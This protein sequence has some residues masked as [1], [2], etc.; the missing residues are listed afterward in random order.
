M[1]APTYYRSLLTPDEQETYKVIVNCLIRHESSICVS[2]SVVE[3][4]S[5]QRVVKAIHL[6]HPELFFIDF[7]CYKLRRGLPPSGTMI[8]FRML[9]GKDAADSVSIT[10][11]RR[12]CKLQKELTSEMS[13]EQQYFQVAKNISSST[14]YV[15]TGSGFWDHTCA[16]PILKGSGVCEGIAKLFLFFC[17]RLQLP[18]TIVA[19]TLNGIPH[20]WN[21]VELKNGKRYVD[22]TG[23]LNSIDFYAIFP[24]ALFRT[25]KQLHQAGYKW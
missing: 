21:M 3:Q 4:Y 23:I 12:A 15:D 11:F 2:Q 19:G 20:A 25:E 8:D 17:Q 1:I 22:V 16:G 18:C 10:L 6:D 14:T 13:I 9:L 5:V 7:W 24:R